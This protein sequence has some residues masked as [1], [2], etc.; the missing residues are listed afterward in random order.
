MV[1]LE[2]LSSAVFP[3]VPKPDDGGATVGDFVANLVV[4]D[5]QPADLPWIML[6]EP[7]SQPWVVAQH[8]HLLGQS[9]DGLGRCCRVNFSQECVQAGQVAKGLATPAKGRGHRGTGKGSGSAEPRRA[10]QASTS[11]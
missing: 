1:K 6:A 8:A 9:L 3:C 11:S 10:A 2:A 5:D 7:R 4:Q